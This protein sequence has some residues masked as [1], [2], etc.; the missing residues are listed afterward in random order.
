MEARHLWRVQLWAG[1]P[2]QLADSTKEETHAGLAKHCHS[3]HSWS[4]PENVSA[5]GVK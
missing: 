4:A 5:E 2:P 3:K 1:S